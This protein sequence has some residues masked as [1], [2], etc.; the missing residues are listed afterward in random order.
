MSL[1]ALHRRAGTVA[2]LL[3]VAALSSQAAADTG[4]AIAAEAPP[5][6]VDTAR[7]KMPVLTP[8][9]IDDTLAIGGSDIDARK[10]ESRMTVAVTINGTGPYRFVVDS[11]AD[12]SVVG[13][14]IA[15]RLKLPAGSRT[16]LN[17]ITDTQLVDRVRVEELEVGPTKVY[18]LQVP[19][20]RERDLGAHGMLGLDALVERRLMMDFENRLI[21][22]DE[23]RTPPPKYSDEIVVTARL[24]KGQLVLTQVRANRERIDAVVDTGSEI[25]IGNNILRDRLLS[26]NRSQFTEVE[27]TG[28]TGTTSKMPIAIVRELKLGSVVLQ[29]VPIAFADIPPFEVFGIDK[30]PSLLL[31]TDVM[32]NFRKVSLDFHNRKVR[33]QL[34]RCEASTIIMKTNAHATRIRSESP[35]ACAR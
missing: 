34:K 1:G 15:N 13:E 4:G 17:S 6:R 27:V 25:S 22:V 19:V 3:A 24:R 18:N 29:N 11:G 35:A 9:D 23:G 20:L 28:V 10:V 26:R 21:S 5:E 30:Q 33:F 32:E 2:T 16:I 14:R 8:A 12:S 31:G 7:G